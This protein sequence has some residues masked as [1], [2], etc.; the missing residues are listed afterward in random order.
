MPTESEGCAAGAEKRRPAIT[1]RAHLLTAREAESDSE[2]G[3]DSI[4]YEPGSV[5]EFHRRASGGS[6]SG[7][8]W[9]VVECA[10]RRENGLILP[11]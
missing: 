9:M 10:H 5:I 11:I 2:S 3:Q 1:G 8:Q 4:N 7:E 6:K